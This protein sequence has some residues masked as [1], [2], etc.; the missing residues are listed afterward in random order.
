M[1]LALRTCTDW[2]FWLYVTTAGAAVH[3][4]PLPALLLSMWLAL[5]RVLHGDGTAALHVIGAAALH[6]V[7]TAALAVS[8]AYH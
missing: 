7:G 2:L 1:W 8:A 5:L 4:I 6:G 3:D